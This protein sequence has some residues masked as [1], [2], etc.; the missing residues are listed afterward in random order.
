MSHKSTSIT[1]GAMIMVAMRWI[2]RFIGIVSTFILARIL[3]PDDFGIVAMASVVVSFADIIFDLGVNVALIQRKHPSQAYYNT[4]WTLRI[5]Q[6]ACV[7]TVLVI[8]APFAAEYYKDPRVTAAVQVMAL[9]LFVGAFENVGIVD[10]Q[11]ELRFADDA[12]YVMFK[13]LVGFFITVALTLIMQSYW[14]MILGT[15]GGRLA[16]VARSYSVHPMRPRFALSEFKEIFAVSQW[17]LVKNISSFLD[18]KLHIFMV[19]GLA[20]T[21]VTGGY[22]LASEIADIP[23]TDLLAPIN[24]VLF[25]A[26]AQAR[27]NLEELTRLLL[28]AQAVQVMVTFPACVGFVL[29]AQE[30]VP[31]ALGEKWLFI[32]PFIQILALSNIIQSINSSANYVL[33]VIGKI[34]LLAVTSWIQ[35]LMFGAGALL[36]SRNLT[37]ER[38]AQLRM[39]SI[40]LT[41]GIS[42][43]LLMRNVPGLTVRMLAQGTGR[44]LL[45]CLA[46]AVALFFLQTQ[47]QAP[48]WAMLVLKVGTGVL[49]YCAVVMLLWRVAGR[50]EGAETYFLSKIKRTKPLPVGVP[51]EAK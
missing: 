24:R 2:D 11:K 35:I 51:G 18:R 6:A 29:T 14:G 31:V 42:Y 49:V 30:F 3:I 44:P 25:P 43:A 7:A 46:M 37:P 1:S 16:A 33:T 15:L 40:V 48:N 41:F 50:P 27:D 34:R 8:L 45:A 9:S 10:F 5:V 38:I 36:L 28:R 20:S 22:T 4:A 19:G 39:A 23:G 47:V 21:G 12:K 17:V 13:R 26:F 32:V